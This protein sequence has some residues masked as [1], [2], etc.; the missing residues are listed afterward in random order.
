MDVSIGLTAERYVVLKA[1]MCLAL[2]VFPF[3]GI[4]QSI[5]ALLFGF[6]AAAVLLAPPL[7][8]NRSRTACDAIWFAQSVSFL[9]VLG[10]LGC[11]FVVSNAIPFF[12][13]VQ[14]L[15]GSLL[16]APIVFGWPAA[17]FVRGCWLHG[18][19]MTWADKVGA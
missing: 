4:M 7:Y 5:F 1:F 2:G 6:L 18:K 13:D 19:R 8:N 14:N 11:G 15:I 12:S 10:V 16:G 17:F 9:L 3:V